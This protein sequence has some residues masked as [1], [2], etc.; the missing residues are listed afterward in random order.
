MTHVCTCCSSRHTGSTR[1]TRDTGS[2]RGQQQ[3]QQQQRYDDDV[4][5]HY[6]EEDDPDMTPRAGDYPS[7]GRDFPS[8]AGFPSSGKGGD[9][10]MEDD[11]YISRYDDDG[12]GNRHYD[13]YEGNYRG[14]GYYDDEYYD[15]DDRYYDSRDYDDS[16][17]D[18]DYYYDDDDR[19]QDYHGSLSRGNSY[20]PPLGVGGS[21]D[22]PPGSDLRGPTSRGYGGSSRPSQK[23]PSGENYQDIRLTSP[24]AESQRSSTKGARRNGNEAYVANS[25]NKQQQQQQQQQVQRGA[26]PEDGY[27]SGK[28]PPGG[29][30]GQDNAYSGDTYRTGG[31]GGGMG[32]RPDTD[33][34]PLYYNSRPPAQPSTQPPPPTTTT[35]AVASQQP[36]SQ[37]MPQS[38]NAR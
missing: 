17:Y 23:A 14:N 2:S 10:P 29:T 1:S 38:F 22:S 12:Y 31:A 34:D 19:Y 33:A 6:D 8:K 26:Y 37:T 5:P 4:T 20:S 21:F 35:S 30:A 27:S 13:D 9:Y 36:A 18:D 7:T 16:R 25:K 32:V 11:R 15:D 28:L 24:G 3:Q